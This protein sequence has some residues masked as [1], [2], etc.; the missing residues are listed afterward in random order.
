MSD[1][2]GGTV[3]N[4]KTFLRRALVLIFVA[5]VVLSGA[6]VIAQDAAETFKAKCVACHGADP[7][8]DTTVGKQW[9]SRTWP[10]RKY[11]K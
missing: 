5:E 11:R 6:L 7:K 9:H 8:G 10:R 3:E 2:F 4:I 1:F